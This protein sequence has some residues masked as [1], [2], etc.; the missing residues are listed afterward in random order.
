LDCDGKWILRNNHTPTKKGRSYD[1]PFFV[2][3][4]GGTLNLFGFASLQVCDAVI[5]TASQANGKRCLPRDI[6]CKN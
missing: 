6:L 1:L 2:G 4:G 5:M 3:A